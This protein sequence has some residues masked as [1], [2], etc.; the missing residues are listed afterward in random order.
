MRNKLVMKLVVEGLV[1]QTLEADLSQSVDSDN[2]PIN[3]Q[4]IGLPKI[5]GDNHINP[6]GIKDVETAYKTFESIRSTEYP[7]EDV[8]IKLN[9]I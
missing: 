7:N 4:I 5:S 2:S 9:Y 6:E 8:T 1:K 3:R